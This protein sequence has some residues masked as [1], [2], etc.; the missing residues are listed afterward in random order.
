MT[1]PGELVAAYAGAL[2][3]RAARARAAA[4]RRVRFMGFSPGHIGFR[5]DNPGERTP[6]GGSPT[7]AI[8]G[9]ALRRERTRPIR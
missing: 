2:T 5:W 8:Y 3:V 4:V 6:G 7:T 1:A 9:L